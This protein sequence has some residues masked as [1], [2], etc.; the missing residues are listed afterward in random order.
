MSDLV[1]RS[2]ADASTESV[3]LLPVGLLC[4][5]LLAV[6][7]LISMSMWVSCPAR[8]LKREL[9]RMGY[10][11]REKKRAAKNRA[12]SYAKRAHSETIAGR[13]FLTIVTRKTCCAKCAGI[14]NIGSEMVY[15]HTPRE[16]RCKLC[17]EMD[18][19][20]KPR[21]STSWERRRRSGS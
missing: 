11:S 14:L 12:I 2:A 8:E 4:R 18:P 13:W 17:A 9:V 5:A 7:S 15:R 1:R 19:D 20:V 16:A 6:Q 3:R 21:P 10:R